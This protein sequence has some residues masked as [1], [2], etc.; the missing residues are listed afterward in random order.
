MT[1]SSGKTLSEKVIDLLALTAG[2]KGIEPERLPEFILATAEALTRVDAMDR[3]TVLEPVTAARPL[4]SA[5]LAA[6]PAA[7]VRPPAARPTQ[8]AAPL[9]ETTLRQE[10]QIRPVPVA[11]T[12]APAAE[13]AR[14]A[15][16]A[17]D[18]ARPAGGAPSALALPEDVTPEELERL[19]QLRG[20]AKKT[21]IEGLHLARS[22][23]S[24]APAPTI[25]L[26]ELTPEEMERL[27]QL[28][29]A[30]KKSFLIRVAEARAAGQGSIVPAQPAPAQAEQAAPAQAQFQP[31][32]A[33]AQAHQAA[34]QQPRVSIQKG[35]RSP[36][37][38]YVPIKQSVTPDYVVC[39]EDGKQMKMLKRHLRAVYNMTP[40]EY[41][42]KWG[43]PDEY[44]MVAPNYARVRS[45][46]AKR[47]GFG[48]EAAEA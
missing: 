15:G 3:G 28:R 19:S 11:E 37:N 44:P 12:T 1:N 32:P 34:P 5:S 20:A 40:E 21:F 2:S 24:P 31:S 17:V 30:A 25:S 10:P 27:K 4:A 43:L 42:Q 16:E 48:G 47:T 22:G 8:A 6:A 46:I 39:L 45:K 14:A 26:E 38:P 41:R 13:D 7:A 18:R 35:A 36:D 33:P 29:G 23:E 9:F